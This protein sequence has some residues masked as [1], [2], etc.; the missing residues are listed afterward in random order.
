MIVCYTIRIVHEKLNTI[1]VEPI[2][3]SHKVENNI[4]KDVLL[5]HQLNLLLT[6]CLQRLYASM[7]SINH[8]QWHHDIASTP[9]ILSNS[10]NGEA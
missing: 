9:H 4:N 8:I 10:S 3:I 6:L 5:K 7:S 1:F 2:G